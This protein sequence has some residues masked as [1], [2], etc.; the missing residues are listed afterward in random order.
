M[1][2]GLR[3]LLPEL[4]CWPHHQSSWILYF[5]SPG[6]PYPHHTL[7]KARGCSELKQSGLWAWPKLALLGLALALTWLVGRVHVSI[8]NLLGQGKHYN[9][10]QLPLMVTPACCVETQLHLSPCSAAPFFCS[11]PGETEENFLL[12][13]FFSS[14]WLSSLYT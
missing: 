2:R 14:H 12:F 5:F 8:C 1:R 11:S 3:S 9:L 13:L 10:L 4:L 7:Q 6:W